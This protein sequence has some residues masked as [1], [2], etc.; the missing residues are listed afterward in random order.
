[1]AVAEKKGKK[2][3]VNKPTS[4]KYKYYTTG[5]KAQKE[6]A[7]CGPGIFMANHKDRFACGKCG[8]TEFSGKAK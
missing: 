6:C 3:H 1:M 8:Y 5:K 4:A 7:K 2:P